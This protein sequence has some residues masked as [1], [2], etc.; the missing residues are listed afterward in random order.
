MNEKSVLCKFLG[1]KEGDVIPVLMLDLK[2]WSL[3]IENTTSQ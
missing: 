3:P 1:H 2:F